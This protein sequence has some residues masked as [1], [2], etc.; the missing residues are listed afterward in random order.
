MTIG[1]DPSVRILWRS[2]RFGIRA[3]YSSTRPYTT[4]VSGAASSRL[5]STSSRRP[6]PTHTTCPSPHNCSP[7]TLI[8]RS[9]R[10]RIARASSEAS[11]CVVNDAQSGFCP[12]PSTFRYEIKYLYMVRIS[13]PLSG[14][15][16]AGHE[17]GEPLEEIVRIVRTRRRLR[18]IL[19]AE[20]RQLAMPQAF[21]R[22]VVQIEVARL[23]AGRG[24]RRRI[25]REVGVL[26]RGFPPPGG[27]VAHRMVGA[28][29]SERQLVGAATGG[30]AQDLMAQTDAEDRHA[31]Q[32]RADRRGEVRHA[33]GIA[34]PV[35]E[36]NAGGVWFGD[37]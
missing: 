37:A 3:P 28:V 27:E 33:L 25:D 16:S 30:Q 20:H 12:E 10:S 8:R 35:G 34:G 9:P 32:E 18:V 31:P 13:L 26:G 7:R 11:L 21:A 5:Y 22:P 36:K 6:P 2:A 1:P 4:D 23:P 19:H 15:G 24:H 29:V 14:A 17:V